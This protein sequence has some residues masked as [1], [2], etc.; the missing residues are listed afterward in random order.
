VITVV[1]F[2]LFASAALALWLAALI[3]RRPSAQGAMPFVWLMSAAAVWCVTSAFDAVAPSLPEKIL[4]SKVQYLGIAPLPPLWLVF[5]AEYVGAP[6]AADRR[7]RFVLVA[8]A[9]TTIGLAFTNEWHGWI[10]SSVRLGPGGLAIYSHGPWF[11]FTIAYSYA[12]ILAGTLVLVRAIRRSPSVFRGQLLVLTAASAI[13]WA[14]NLM[15]ITGAASPG[16]FDLTPLAFAFSGVLFAWALH[17]TYLFNLIPVARDMVVDSL[18][19]A[20]VVVDPTCRVI[21]MN[22]A[23]RNLSD[24][25]Q[26]WLGKPAADVFPLL[27]GCELTLASTPSSTLVATSGP[28]PSYYDVRTMPVRAKRHGFAAW[29]VLLRDVSEQRRA[30]AER[31]A[32]EARVQEQQ[33]RESLSVL[34]GGLAHDFNNLLAGIVG[35]AD[36]LAMQVPPSSEM[37]SNVGAIILGAQR[38][39]DLV[40]KMLAYA[41][42]RHGSMD[43]VDLDV[44][45]GELLDLLRASAARHCT[46]QYHGQPAAI[47]GDPTQVRQVIMNLIINAAE[48]VDEGTGTVTVS[49]GLERL[50]AWKLADMTFGGDAAPGTYAFLEVRDNGPGMDADTMS[51]IFN[52][53]FTTKPSG[54]GL[55]LAA[56]QGIVRGHHGALHVDSN[57]GF[58]SRFCAWFPVAPK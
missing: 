33:K 25:A 20:V 45:T 3:Y 10:W 55:G 5:L 38:A 35:N 48:A 14:F 34:A 56:V 46:L 54:H 17:R 37:G 42:E 50:S 36:L 31:D 18:S 30:Q 9:T 51:R 53:F 40:S 57:P 15:Y 52:P 27:D 6:W 49:T 21:D 41:G 8:L 29:V 16:G 12:L 26:E 28:D 22:A 58:G 4:W 23:A 19:D 1:P 2:A 32:L 43:L 47:V 11:W 39:A 44:L 24:T 13:P 7:L